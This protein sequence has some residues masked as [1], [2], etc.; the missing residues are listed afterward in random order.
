MFS[1]A[2]IVSACKSLHISLYI[3]AQSHHSNLQETFLCITAQP[4]AFFF[5]SLSLLGNYL[6][7]FDLPWASFDLELF[8]PL[9][10][11][12][13]LEGHFYGPGEGLVAP[14]GFLSALLMVPNLQRQVTLYSVLCTQERQPS[15][16][17]LVP[18]W[19]WGNTLQG[20]NLFQLSCL[21]TGL[22]SL[23]FLHAVK[24]CGK[25]EMLTLLLRFLQRLILQ[26][27]L[28]SR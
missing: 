22:N 21:F 5:F 20:R 3:T 16:L 7:S 12:Q 15:S 23:N 8:T 2:L 11:P 1:G 10:C 19:T 24:T 14:Q 4:P 25:L 9:L 28:Y 18:A 13:P 27:R 17:D 26:A 6:C